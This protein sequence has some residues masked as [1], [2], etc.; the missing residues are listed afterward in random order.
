M[1]VSVHKIYQY[2]HV[3]QL[4]TVGDY[5]CLCKDN[6]PMNR[7]T[8]KAHKGI[9]NKLIFRSLNPDRVPVDIVGAGYEVYARI[10]NQDNHVI[11][12]EKLCKLGPAKGLITLNIDA[13]DVAFLAAGVY[14][15]VLILTEPF[16]VGQNQTMVEKPL[17]SDLNDNV[18][19]QI[20]ITEQAFYAPRPSIT[21]LPN[22]WTGDLM[23]PVS[24]QPIKSFYSARIPGS[25]VQ[26][27]LDSVHTFSTYT[28]NFTGT[29]ETY[30]TLDES[31]EPYLNT[32]Q[33][34]KIYPSTMSQDIEYVGYTGTQAWT[35]QANFMWLKFRY[36]PSTEV[37]DPG[38]FNK[39]IV[40]T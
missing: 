10:M 18:Y 26:N 11:V 4:L 37:L 13:G 21:L 19:M 24:G 28:T 33:W 12:F 3:Y 14:N 2:D 20:E 31:P 29:L 15:M 25:R 5:M 9:D 34:F 16:V 7:S 40:R 36:I 8:L 22:D 1:D 17:Y 23:Y 27:H 6:G 35:F 32:S 38:H 30:G 39:L